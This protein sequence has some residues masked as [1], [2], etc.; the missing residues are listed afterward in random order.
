MRNPAD[1]RF[2]GR[3]SELARLRASWAQ[4]VGGRPVM[5][6][7]AGDAGVGKSR[8]TRE[9][10]AAVTA[11]GATGLVGDCLDLPE[12]S[13]PLWPFV[14]A[15]REHTSA[16]DDADRAELLGPPDSELL[17]VLPELAGSAPAPETTAG[18]SAQGRLFELLLGL[19]GRLAQR[20]PLVLVVEDIQW[21]DRSTRDLLAFLSKTLRRERIMVIAT[22]RTDALYRGHPLRPFL[23]ELYRARSVQLLE[24]PPFTRDEVAQQLAAITGG[25]VPATV[26][27]S[28]FARSEGNAFYGE[29]LV[30]VSCE[31]DR[32]EL[33]PTLRDI[34]LTRVERR[35][36]AAQ[37][38]LRI[39][40]VGGRTVPVG[41]LAEVCPLSGAELT[42]ALREAVAH[43]LLVPDGSVGYAFCHALLREA[44]YQ[45]LLP[46]ERG[47]LHL[48]YGT[49]LTARPQLAGDSGAL[50]SE[51]AYHW[52]AAHELPEALAALV[53]AGRAAEARWGF[54]EA[55]THYE[56]AL[57]LWD[58]VP[59]A[60]DRTGIDHLTLSRS[61][62][63]A[64]N[65]AGNHARASALIRGAI[66][67][68]GPERAGLLWERLG[69]YLWAAGDCDRALEAYGEAL[70]LVPADPPSAARAR[71]LAAQGQ[72][73]MLLAR[74]EEARACCERAIAIAHAV[75]ARAEEGHALNTLGCSLAYLGEPAGAVTHLR[76]AL[77][78]AEEVQDL[79]DLGRAY[80][81]LSEILGGPLNRL[82]EA[83]TVA[84]DGRRAAQRVGL[85]RD[86]GVSLEVNA[87]T[88]L[89]SLG[90]WAEA[91]AILDTAE[92]RRPVDMAA[93]EVHLCR[94]R[95]AIATGSFERGSQALADARRA[96][97]T[98][99]DP[100]FHTTLCAREAELSLWQGRCTQAAEAIAA[101]L[102]RLDDSDDTWF[103]GPLLWLGAWA[104]ADADADAD[105]ATEPSP[106]ERQADQ[107]VRAAGRR[108]A[109]VS[110]VTVAY[111]RMCQAE[112]QR[113]ADPAATQPWAAAAAA[114]EAVGHPYLL[115]YARWRE[116][117]ALLCRRRARDAA[118][119]LRAAHE[120][121]QG[122]DAAP[123]RNEIELLA[124][125]ARIDLAPA[126]RPPADA[127]APADARAAEAGL[128]R[129]ERQVLELMAAGQTNREI[130]QGLFVSEKT[131][132]AHVSNILG[133]LG[134]R[135][136]VEAATAAHRLGLLSE[137]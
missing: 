21:A 71:V 134:V 124:R 98:I 16:L 81:N 67:R 112:A 48:R 74:F 51:L 60:E 25:R 127:V 113:R 78:I 42:E 43:H 44:V 69:R 66:E 36:P 85:A 27:D 92:E 129:R 100:Q 31:D 99:L 34:L 41:L 107:I 10:L 33:P 17:R 28:V 2:V 5:Y 83:L 64:A 95:L 13:L 137:Q 56:R 3:R 119:A 55:Q 117:E 45:E 87:A 8:L 79:D 46:G 14:S 122:L 73:L 7:L 1:T 118:A 116:G 135:G 76:A 126:A 38:V 59:D 70:R 108:G 49:V 90:R 80:Q 53:L 29:E 82:E 130:A 111:A 96:M 30:A 39:A 136:R 121:A 20:A 93:I 109:F 4:V 40:A 19:L 102:A 133:K 35:S 22:H 103:L 110:P 18:A 6:S 37:E 94:A 91:A 77:E 131:A 104:E 32:D 62:A 132:A 75:G 12:G 114:W 105:A 89:L 68:A 123:L 106:F 47:A 115:A 11:E 26:V 84:L 52:S 61:A 88:A 101:G 72:S 120:I 54:A 15:I 97:G 125:R 50:P 23:A 65:L 58:R 9:F 128:T 86:Y 24:L 63:E 57:E